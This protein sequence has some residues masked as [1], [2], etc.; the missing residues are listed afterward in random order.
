MP[1]S[2]LRDLSRELGVPEERLTS[3][4]VRACERLPLETYY[5]F[6]S[7]PAAGEAPSDAGPARLIA[8]FPSPDD[9]LAFAQRNGYATSAQIR[10]VAARELIRLLLSVPSIEAIRF[11]ESVDDGSRRG[12]P[13]GVKVARTDLLAELVSG[14]R[15]ADELSA[16]GFDRLQFGVDFTRR[17]A[18]RAALTEAVEAVIATY[19]PPPGSLDRRPRSIFATTAVEVWLRANG[20]PHAH[21]R[22][23]IDVAG[24][25][26]WQGAEELYEIDCGTEQRL[27]VQLLIMSDD[28][29]QFVERVVVT[30]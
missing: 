13:P 15:E 19:V 22:R 7:G 12:F 8:A 1:E 6:R 18:F 23:W 3:L 10:A 2:S 27:L 14:P 21:Q 25:Q 28:E 5:V 29:R 4:I 11:L 30:S 24:Q 26:E 17:G 9:A 16:K 20:F